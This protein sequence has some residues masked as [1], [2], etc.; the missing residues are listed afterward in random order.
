[1]KTYRSWA[2]ARGAGFARPGIGGGANCVA[3][4]R[5]LERVRLRHRDDRSHRQG[6]EAHRQAIH[7]RSARARD[8]SKDRARHRAGGLRQAAGHSRVHQFA[9]FESGGTVKMVPDANR[10]ANADSGHHRSPAEGAGRRNVTLLIAGERTCARR[11]HGARCCARSCPRPRTWRRS[12]QSNAL[13]ISD[14]AANARRIVD[15]V[16]RLDKAA[17]A[18]QKCPADGSSRRATASS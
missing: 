18:G 9:A 2:L 3:M 16:E 13:I 17:P 5:I 15:M 4:R 12:V 11:R 14:R 6:R 8:V 1:M 10:A 7:R